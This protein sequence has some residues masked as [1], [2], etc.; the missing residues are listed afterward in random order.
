[1]E[2]TVKRTT[3]AKG[4]AICLMLIHHLYA[5]KERIA[6]GI[7]YIPTFP[8]FDFDFYLGHF[9]KICV[10]SFLF[11]SGYGLY[12]R[13]QHETYMFKFIVVKVFNFYKVYWTYFLLFVPICLF[14]LGHATLF[15][16]NELIWDSSIVVFLK[17]FI[18]LSSSYN[19]EWWFVRVYLI[20]I[21][22]FFPIFMY[23]IKR[24]VL[25]FIVLTAMLLLLSKWF[26]FK[27]LAYPLRWQICFSFGMLFAC[28][29]AFKLSFFENIEKLK[30]VQLLMIVLL[31]VFVGL[32]NQLLNYHF[33]LSFDFILAPVF[34]YVMLCLIEK[35][36]FSN[37]FVFFGKY[38][39]QVWLI[40]TFFCY[41][42]FQEIIYW[43][44]Y[45][46]LIFILLLLTSFGFVVIVEHLRNFVFHCGFRRKWNF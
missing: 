27:N 25:V 44:H 33:R 42:I 35:N 3:M 22:C 38:S 30:T 32:C 16:S 31:L 4:V 20:M 23:L 8:F 21:T 43:P 2:M 5:F 18:G 13:C 34:L 45:S 36:N 24:N 15:N 10:A 26:D 40:H 41:Y 9:G 37:I 46:P 6:L 28:L 1:M 12:L 14:S 39:F 19:R 11:L 7:S 17:N 29:N